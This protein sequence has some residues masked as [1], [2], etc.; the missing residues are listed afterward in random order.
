MIDFGIKCFVI[1]GECLFPVTATVV[2][3]LPLIFIS[4]IIF[5]IVYKKFGQHAQREEAC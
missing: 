4:L 5:V 1:E 3:N 2:Y